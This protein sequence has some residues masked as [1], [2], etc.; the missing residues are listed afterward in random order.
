VAAND[1]YEPY[2]GRGY[3][4][5]ASY[6]DFAIADITSSSCNQRELE[7]Y[8]R[9]EA[10]TVGEFPVRWPSGIRL[11]RS[12][13]HAC[14]ETVT[15]RVD[16][17]LSYEPAS[18]FVRADGSTYGGYNVSFLASRSWC[19]I[20]SQGYPCG[21]HP[22]VVHLNQS[23]FGDSSYSEDYRRRLI[24][25]ETGH[26]LGLDHHCTSDAIMNDGTSGCNGGAWT[27]I[28]GY[29]KTDRD[30]IHSLYPNW[31]Y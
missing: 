30:G 3:V 1:I 12:I 17:K 22:S 2:R 16:I 24:M 28:N 25:H 13:D 5:F 6:T 7:A 29:Q 10:T 31:R 11:R 26:S 8:N 27:N 14:D 9:V 19:H 4:W 18:N 23:R 20:W 21:S 15:A